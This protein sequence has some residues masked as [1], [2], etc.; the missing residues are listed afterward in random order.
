MSHLE[1]TIGN[2]GSTVPST[3]AI[4]SPV[5]ATVKFSEQAYSF[6]R[7][8]YNEKLLLFIETARAKKSGVPIEVAEGIGFEK[9]YIE[10]QLDPSK[11]WDKQFHHN[12]E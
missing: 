9:F 3:N 2:K 4:Q 5:R 12:P 1:K 8:T 7:L 11:Y 10:T 6:K